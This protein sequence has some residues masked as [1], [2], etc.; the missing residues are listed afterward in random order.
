MRQPR[1]TNRQRSPQCL[2]DSSHPQKHFASFSRGK[3]RFG[4]V[5]HKTLVAP[6]FSGPET[7]QGSVGGNPQILESA[8]MPPI[9]LVRSERLPRLSRRP[10]TERDCRGQILRY[11]RGF[12]CASLPGNK[13]RIQCRGEDSS[14]T[15]SSKVLGQPLHSTRHILTRRERLPTR[16][17]LISVGVQK[18]VHQ[19]AQAYLHTRPESTGPI[20]DCHRIDMGLGEA[21]SRD[22]AA[23]RFIVD[24]EPCS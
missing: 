13:T 3:Q 20:K 17:V 19:N 24:K 5:I 23:D 11:Q 14:S 1:R 16:K 12:A 18:M 7:V 4:E 10:E 8:P 2:P 15:I 22:R 21:S 9:S 6:T